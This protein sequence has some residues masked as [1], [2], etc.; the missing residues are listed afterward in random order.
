MI[1]QRQGDGCTGFVVGFQVR[2]FVGAFVAFARTVLSD[3]ADQ[4]QLVLQAELDALREL[5]PG[6]A[7]ER[8]LSW[9]SLGGE[10]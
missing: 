7:L 5:P 2:Q 3:A 1:P 4:V 9:F 8:V 6:Q 10:A